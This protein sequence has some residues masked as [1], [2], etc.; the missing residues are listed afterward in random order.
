MKVKFANA[1]VD[2]WK[3][4]EGTVVA[5]GGGLWMYYGTVAGLRTFWEPYD[6]IKILVKCGVD[7]EEYL[8]NKITWLEPHD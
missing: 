1:E 7:I 3:V 2:V 8:P 5:L 4:R 6:G